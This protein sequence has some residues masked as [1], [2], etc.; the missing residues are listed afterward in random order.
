[1]CVKILEE[2]KVK[3]GTGKKKKWIQAMSR[4]AMY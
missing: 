4:N 3:N 1:M 2:K